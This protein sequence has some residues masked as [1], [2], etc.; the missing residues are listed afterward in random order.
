[1]P[2]WSGPTSKLAGA[3]ASFPG[4]NKTFPKDNDHCGDRA[5]HG[6]CDDQDNEELVPPAALK[7]QGSLARPKRTD[8]ETLNTP[9]SFR[10]FE[11]EQSGPMSCT[12]QSV[13]GLVNDD[14]AALLTISLHNTPVSRQSFGRRVGATG[15]KEQGFRAAEEAYSQTAMKHSSCSLMRET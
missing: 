10:T 5:S 4:S 11:Q 14:L 2:D 12:G 3:G 13:E 15:W 7:R 1:V 9:P 8:N 6:D